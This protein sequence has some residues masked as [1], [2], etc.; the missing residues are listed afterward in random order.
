[1]SRFVIRP[2]VY[3][4]EL[5]YLPKSME[6][7]STSTT[8][9]FGE[10]QRGPDTPTLITSWLQYQT[11]FGGYF[12][13]EKYLPY[14]VEGFFLNGGCRC[15]VCKVTNG[16]YM[17]AL[18]KVETIDEVS[19]LYAPNAQATVG[20]V[21]AMIGHAERFKR[22]V[23]LDSLRGQDISSVTKPA[24]SS[25]AAVYYPWIYVNQPEIK[26]TLLVPPGG[27]IAGIYAHTD[28]QWGVHR[29]PA[30]QLIKGV[31]DLECTLNQQAQDDL[32]PKGINCIRKF[33]GRG[34]LVWGARTLSSDPETKYINVRRLMIYLEQSIKIGTSWVTFE[35]NN[36]T[37]WAKVRST[38]E[39]FLRHTWV[40]GM[41]QGTTTQEAYFVKC[42]R[43]TMT[44]NDLNKGQI[45]IL[46]GAA[47]NKPAEFTI[48]HITQTSKR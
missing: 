29:A 4:E 26:H 23:I 1:M 32:S 31:V 20:L 27:H 21:A 43:T 6:G 28:I 35:E 22:F 24:E 25:F 15:Y 37:T 11:V 16:D 10:T 42:D 39:E 13:E 30:N 45:V 48:L 36:E 41:L 40:N 44:Q 38:I 5:S 18:S 12:G 9:F 3:I 19:I 2:G 7:V 34:I 17:S 47:I 46:V 14:S 33:V 8:A